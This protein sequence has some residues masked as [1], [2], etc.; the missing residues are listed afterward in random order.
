MATNVVDAMYVRGHY[1]LE[2][3]HEPLNPSEACLEQLGVTHAYVPL[4]GRAWVARCLR[5]R[6]RTGVVLVHCMCACVVLVRWC[7]ARA[8]R[9]PH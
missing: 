8:L 3:R 5:T 4:L 6:A 1:P 7:G 9:A 2:F